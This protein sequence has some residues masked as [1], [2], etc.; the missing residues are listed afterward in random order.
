MYWYG[1]IPI[2]TFK[3]QVSPALKKL[4][5][6]SLKTSSNIEFLLRPKI[7]QVKARLDH[8]SIQ[9]KKKYT[10]IF[11]ESVRDSIKSVFN[12][13]SNTTIFYYLR[14][15][16]DI[17]I[18]DYVRVVVSIDNNGIVKKIG[19]FDINT[20]DLLAI[21][22]VMEIEESGLTKYRI[23]EG[24][25]DVYSKQLFGEIRDIYHEHVYSPHGDFALRPVKPGAGSRDKAIEE[26]FDQ[27]QMKILQYHSLTKNLLNQI[28]ES[29][30]TASHRNFHNLLTILCA[31]KGE[32]IY[33]LSF[34]NLFDL[35]IQKENSIRNSINSIEN[36]SKHFHVLTDLKSIIVNWKVIILTLA[37]VWI[38]SYHFGSELFPQNG[39]LL[40]FVITGFM[41][42]IIKFFASRSTKKRHFPQ[43]DIIL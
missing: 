1:W 18:R 10:E 28:E 38:A 41:W 19:L 20:P 12:P 13:S 42:L 21:A 6:N 25:E 11:S 16:N 22:E 4:R 39:W 9:K 3:L 23:V 40:S 43:I 26:I 37:A 35:S 15:F 27:Y 33:A 7:D 24:D 29:Y 32:M 31:A 14:D 34:I 17:N 2:L 8:P 36:L 30:G 5:K